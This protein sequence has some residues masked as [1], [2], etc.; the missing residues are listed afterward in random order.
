MQFSRR[1]L[2]MTVIEWLALTFGGL[3]MGVLWGGILALFGEAVHHA[4]AAEVVGALA[5][6]DASEVSYWLFLLG[7]GLG[8]VG[9]AI[10]A[11]LEL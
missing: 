11:A 6:G 5:T 10:S 1:F 4:N 7:F 9:Q 2:N 8:T 3:L